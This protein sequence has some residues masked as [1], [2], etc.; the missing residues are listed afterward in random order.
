MFDLHQ[1]L[2][3]SDWPLAAGGGAY[4]ILPPVDKVRWTPLKFSDPYYLSTS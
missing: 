1:F 3:R 4:K 2:T